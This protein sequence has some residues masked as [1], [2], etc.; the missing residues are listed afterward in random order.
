M[1]ILQSLLNLTLAAAIT[2][3]ARAATVQNIDKT[4]ATN[5]PVADIYFYDNPVGYTWTVNGSITV[6]DGTTT[7]TIDSRLFVGLRVGPSDAGN[8]L[9]TLT[10]T[11]GGS[12]LLL[13][14][15]HSAD[16]VLGRL[17]HT[18]GGNFVGTLNI[19]GGLAVIMGGRDMRYDGGANT[20]NVVNGSLNYTN[21][22]FGWQEGAGIA[23]VNHF[24][25][26]DGALIVPGIISDAAGFSAWAVSSGT[27]VE[28]NDITVAASGGLTLN[29]EN[30]G[31]FT[32]ITAV[33]E[34]SVAL[35]GGLGLLVLL[36]RRR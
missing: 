6:G 12:T 29:F 32:T 16:P 24:I 23:L 36:R 7:P 20:I 34:S 2:A 5:P 21:S 4:F 1:P 33:P 11:V 27:G 8:G 15:W 10:S 28:L 19:D 17:G 25:G 35:L 14:G 18:S 26:A 31:S 3:S 30:N 9:L 22:L 13:D